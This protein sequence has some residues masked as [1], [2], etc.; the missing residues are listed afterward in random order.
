[1]TEQHSHARVHF[2]SHLRGSSEQTDDG[3]VPDNELPLKVKNVN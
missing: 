1:M 3:T 2:P